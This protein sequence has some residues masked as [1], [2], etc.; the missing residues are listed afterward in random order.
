MSSAPHNERPWA[1]AELDALEDALDRLDAPQLP[2]TLSAEQAQRI[3]GRLANYRAIASLSR[4]LLSSH[5][6]PPSAIAAALAEARAAA[7]VP[8]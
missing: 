4:E 1:P 5:A 7:V 3:G 6:A 2:A 8:A